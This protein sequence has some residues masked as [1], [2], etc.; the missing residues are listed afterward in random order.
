MKDAI[1]KYM[2][3]FEEQFPDHREHNDRSTE[4]L[5]VGKEVSPGKPF[6]LEVGYD[7]DKGHHNRDLY[8]D[9]YDRKFHPDDRKEYDSIFPELAEKTSLLHHPSFILDASD[10]E[11]ISE[12][13]SMARDLIHHLVEKYGTEESHPYLIKE[14]Y[15]PL[16]KVLMERLIESEEI[17]NR[18]ANSMI[19][20]TP[21]ER[22]SYTNRFKSHILHSASD[23]YPHR[24]K[25]GVKEH[26][27]KKDTG[28]G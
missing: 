10:D 6:A 27:S 23:N 22:K 7:L 26:F 19:L 20:G 2:N 5:F 21:H 14:V 25:Q 3:L 9:N 28:N 24:W 15:E 18:L 16:L 17:S 4:D 13:R 12:D 1:K 8:H 11:N